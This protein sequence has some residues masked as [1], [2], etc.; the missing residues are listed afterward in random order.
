MLLLI[1]MFSFVNSMFNSD[2]WTL[3]LS[4]ESESDNAED[5]VMTRVL[6]TRSTF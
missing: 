4:L 1:L 6:E 2:G 5:F 3:L